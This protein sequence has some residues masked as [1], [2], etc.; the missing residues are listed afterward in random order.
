MKGKVKFYNR[1]QDFGF[2]IGTNGDEYYFNA[3]SIAQLK[4]KDAVAFSIED[5][6]RGK[7]ARHIRHYGSPSPLKT[8]LMLLVALIIGVIIG[9]VLRHLF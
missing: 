2:V 1:K 7:I 8:G 5:S 6:P 3:L 4:E 9:V